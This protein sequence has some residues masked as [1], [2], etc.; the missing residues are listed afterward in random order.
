MPT[1]TPDG[2]LCVLI[3]CCYVCCWMGD[4]K[5]FVN[6]HFADVEKLKKEQQELKQRIE[7]LERS[8]KS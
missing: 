5:E 8:Q 6:Q 3:L 2:G 1:P 7:Y 4:G